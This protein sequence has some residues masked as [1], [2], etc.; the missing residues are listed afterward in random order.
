M[1]VASFFERAS[2]AELAVVLAANEEDEMGVWVA[3]HDVSDHPRDHGLAVDFDQRLR[4]MKLFLG[5]EVIARRDGD[6]IPHA[7]SA[8][9]ISDAMRS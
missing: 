9:L 5:K 6:Y 7:A 8:R 1:A 4:K 2:D 3:F